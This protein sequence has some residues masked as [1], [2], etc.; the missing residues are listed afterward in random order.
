MQTGAARMAFRLEFSAEAE[1]DF[2]LN[3]DYLLRSCL[4]FG[5]N[6][7]SALDRS[8]LRI[9]ELHTVAGSAM[10]TSCLA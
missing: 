1:H 9:A 7:E 8:A 10:T 3:F 5:E 6:L 4:D 2:G